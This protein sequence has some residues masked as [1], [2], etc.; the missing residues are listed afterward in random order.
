M[1]Q[2]ITELLIFI[3]IG[4]F[5]ISQIVIPVADQTKMFP[6][7][8]RRNKVEKQIEEENTNIQIQELE[9]KVEDL[10]KQ[11]TKKGK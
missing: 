5:F 3:A 7:F 9:S 1:I 10:K 6:M 2:L 8:S 11:Q 4:T